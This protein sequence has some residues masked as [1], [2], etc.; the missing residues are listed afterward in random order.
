MKLRDYILFLLAGLALHQT[1]SIT[2][3]LPEGWEQLT[4]TAIGVEGTFP[5]FLM[6]LNKQKFTGQQIAHAGVA[7]QIAFLCVGIGVAVGWLIDTLF[8]VKRS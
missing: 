4:G 2:H 3:K 8:G 6:I 5:I 1:A 7:Y